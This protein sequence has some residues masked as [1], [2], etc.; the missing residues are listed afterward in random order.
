MLT[1]PY[2]KDYFTGKQLIA[3]LLAASAVVINCL[4]AAF[5]RNSFLPIFAL[6]LALPVLLVTHISIASGFSSTNTGTNFRDSEPVRFWAD[7]CITG[8]G[9]LICCLG[10]WLGDWG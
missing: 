2:S 7:N 6:C 9:V 3:F 8:G 4:A 10:A 5:Y 1:P